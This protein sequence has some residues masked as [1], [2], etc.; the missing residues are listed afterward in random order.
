M[1]PRLSGNWT[2]ANQQREH[3]CQVTV[4]EHPVV[5]ELLASV[6]E[7]FLRLTAFLAIF[8]SM[9]IFEL[10]SPR[11][12]RAE[13]IGAIRFRRWAVNI[14]LVVIST[15]VLRIVFPTAAVGAAVWA[16]G[17]DVGLLNI[18]SVSPWVAGIGAFVVLDFAVWLE[19][20]ASHRIPILWAIHRVHHSDA[21]FDV[22]TALRFHPIEIVLSMV[23]KIG[24]VVALGAPAGAVLAFEIILNGASMF[25]HANGRLPAGLDRALRWLIVTPDMHRIHHST[26]RVETDSNY[27]FNLSWWDRIFST[28]L[29]TPEGGATQ[30]TLGLS[31][32]NETGPRPLLALLLV[33]F[34]RRQRS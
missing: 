25:N 15:V 14:S 28:Y 8:A 21:G 4:A 26:R 9:A 7:S 19:H 24:I 29:D 1:P 10:V 27:G 5:S 13:M 11:L 31:E 17:A 23:W 34:R 30:L 2:K 22:S 3:T 12:T 6:P 18:V 32:F 33:P 20:V 16:A